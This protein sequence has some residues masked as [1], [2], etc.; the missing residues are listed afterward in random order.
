MTIYDFF[1]KISNASF[2]IFVAPII[3]MSF[4]KCGK[5]V[6]IAKGTRFAGV[7]NIS[8]GNNVFIG[9]HCLFLCTKAR[10]LIGDGV[11]FGPNVTVITGGH[12]TRITKEPMYM[13]NDKKKSS[14]LDRDIVFEGDN[15]IGANATIL[16]G[17]TIAK[18][19]VVAAGAVVTHD[20]D[21]FSI[22]A[23]VPARTI[24]NRKADD[25]G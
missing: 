2:K 7:G 15:W 19:T 5:K 16:R 8:V 17:V 14:D 20:T 1:K 24:K 9:E 10:V 18:G 25:N 11:M 22:V 6:K 4:K 13:I 3:R 21:P 23:G 12:E